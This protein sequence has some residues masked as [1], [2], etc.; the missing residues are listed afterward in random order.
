M[1]ILGQFRSGLSTI[2]MGC[3]GDGWMVLSWW[4]DVCHLLILCWVAMAV[5]KERV[6]VAVGKERVAGLLW[7]CVSILCTIKKNLM[8]SLK[9][10]M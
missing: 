4:F 5:G 8:I 1:L 7:L 10:L 3:G 6:A 9:T 2:E